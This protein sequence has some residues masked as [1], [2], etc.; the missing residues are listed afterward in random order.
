MITVVSV[1]TRV[2]PSPSEASRRAPG[3]R[4]SISSVLRMMVGIIMMPSAPPPASAEKCFTGRT[5][6]A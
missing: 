2:A 4:R 5:K 1:R 6:A 3:T